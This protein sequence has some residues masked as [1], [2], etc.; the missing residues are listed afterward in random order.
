MKYVP[1]TERFGSISDLHERLGEAVARLP[2]ECLPRDRPTIGCSFRDIPPVAYPDMGV[3]ERLADIAAEA[4]AE[5]GEEAW[6]ALNA[7]WEER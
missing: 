5:M 4:R 1:Y 3:V 7:E 2:A 6:N